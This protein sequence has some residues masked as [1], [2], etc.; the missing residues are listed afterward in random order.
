MKTLEDDTH[1]HYEAAKEAKKTML[2]ALYNIK[3]SFNNVILE[4]IPASD[5]EMKWSMIWNT[6]KILIEKC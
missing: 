3:K 4:W 6:R 2:I 1:W 5:K